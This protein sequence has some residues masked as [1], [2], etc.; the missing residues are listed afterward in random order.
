M[1]PLPQKFQ[2]W[3]DLISTTNPASTSITDLTDRPWIREQLANSYEEKLRG[4]RQGRYQDYDEYRRA[5][6][7]KFLYKAEGMS[8]SI[9]L[10]DRGGWS[11]TGSDLEWWN[12]ALWSESWEG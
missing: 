7:F 5:D 8:A 1:D 12:R 2:P 11:D 4:E 6:P 10:S 3:K 9:A